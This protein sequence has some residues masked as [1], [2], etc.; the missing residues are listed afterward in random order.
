MKGLCDSI[1]FYNPIDYFIKIWD[2]YC[3][4]FVEG[5]A[6]EDQC[7]SKPCQN[8]GECIQIKY[9]RYKCDCQGTRYY[10][11]HCE[12]GKQICDVNIEVQ[13]EIS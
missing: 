6:L 5:N 13:S 7:A 3:T 8:G 10:G 11:K 1:L 12:Q 9:R 4:L 2:K